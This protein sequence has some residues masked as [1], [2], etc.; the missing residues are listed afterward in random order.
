[1]QFVG[2]AWGEQVVE[3]RSFNLKLDSDDWSLLIAG[4]GLQGRVTWLLVM[5]QGDGGWTG[6]WTGVVATGWTWLKAESACLLARSFVLILYVSLKQITHL[7]NT[8]EQFAFSIHAN[9]THWF[10]HWMN[11]HNILNTCKCKALDINKL[12]NKKYCQYIDQL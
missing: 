10:R 12:Q 11:K 7:K 5:T 9:P 2:G 1:M 3:S 4:Q 6:G 8:A